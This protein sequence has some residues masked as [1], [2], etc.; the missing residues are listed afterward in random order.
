MPIYNVEKYLSKCLDSILSQSYENLEIILVNDGS[1]DNSLSVCKAYAQQD[2]R[3]V[4]IDKQNE[5]VSV[6]R[7]TGLEK[8]TGEYVAFVDPDD[9][10]EP[11]MY[12][13][14]MKQLKKWQAPVCLCNFYKDTKKRSQAKKFDFEEQV[15]CGKQIVEELVNNMIGMP[16]LL[17]KYVYIMGCVWRGLY[18]REFL[19]AHHLNFIPKLTVMEDLVFMVQILLKCDK[20]AID[21]GVHYHYVQ[22][23]TSTLHSYNKKMWDDQLTVYEHLEESIREAGLEKEMRNRLDYRYIGMIFSAIKNETFI[24]RESD[25]KETILRMMDIFT[26]DTL[27]IVLERVKPIQIER[28]STTH[29]KKKSKSSKKDKKEREPKVK[30]E[31]IKKTKKVTTSNKPKKQGSSQKNMEKKRGTLAQ[32]LKGTPSSTSL[33]KESQD[34]YNE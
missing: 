13:A 11:E 1:K 22:H 33:Y 8:A 7:N 3:I 6:A 15:L 32:R 5:G 29:K 14:M 28:T 9:W 24:K 16:D 26:D 20:V 23:A 2:Q 18:K 17:P 30:K 21:Q 12:E 25:F 4:V 27:K 31:K 10:I 34:G 19:E